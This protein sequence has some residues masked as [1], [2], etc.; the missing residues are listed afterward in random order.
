[1]NGSQRNVLRCLR[2]VQEFVAAHQVA[3]APATL[4]KQ[5]EELDVV[6]A[7]L[8]K[9]TL[10]QDAG[11]RLTKAETKKQKGLRVALWRNHMQ[12]IARVAREI[13]GRSGMDAA[14]KLPRLSV[15]HEVVVTAAGA[16]AE[17]AQKSEAAFVEHGLSLDFVAEL[18]AAAQE[19]N[20]SLG[21]RDA[22]Q[23]RRTTATAAVK[24]QLKRGRRA[25]RLLNAILSPRLAGDPELLAAWNNVRKIKPVLSAAEALPSGPVIKAA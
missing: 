10:D 11:H 16:M 23:R 20:A 1:L 17:S 24:D 14:L 2:R 15:A 18:K 4:G 25:V 19:L 13:F 22:T 3:D 6:I 5:R 9:E 12:P 21:A 7:Q 8:S